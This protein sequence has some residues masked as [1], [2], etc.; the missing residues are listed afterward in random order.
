MD[1]KVTGMLKI[2][3]FVKTDAL[4]IKI[5]QEKN[6]KEKQIQHWKEIIQLQEKLKTNQN[7]LITVTEKVEAL[8]KEYKELEEV[9]DRDVTKEFAFR[10][11]QR[12]LNVAC[13]DFDRLKEEENTL[14]K[15]LQELDAR[16]PSDVYLS[17]RDRQI[18]GNFPSD[19]KHLH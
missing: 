1:Y 11:K 4:T 18:I 10:T 12:D 19:W 13:K 2:E 14:T 16:P 7:R 6:V 5:F 15:K 17:S 9:S 3:N 8:H